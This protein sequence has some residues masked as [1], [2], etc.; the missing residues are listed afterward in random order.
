MKLF[1]HRA[2]LEI[3]T[4][5][6]AIFTSSGSGQKERRF[7]HSLNES[8]RPQ[9]GAPISHRT[10]AAHCLQPLRHP[11]PPGPTTV[12]T[13]MF[14]LSIVHLICSHHAMQLA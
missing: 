6:V 5:E 13:A 14:C 2:K 12:R 10:H 4:R 1:V 3:P 11:S 9:V 8:Q 7:D